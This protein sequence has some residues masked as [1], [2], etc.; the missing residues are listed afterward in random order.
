M[1]TIS[2]L[3]SFRH[4]NFR[5]FFSGQFVSMTG[6]WMQNTAQM[7]L[8]YRLT[9]SPVLLGLVGFFGQ[10]P[11]LFLGL[12]GGW[13]ADRFDRRRVIV[14]TQVLAMIQAFLLAALTYSGHVRVEQVMVLALFLGTVTAFD[15]PAR[16]S[17][18]VRMVGP[19]DLPNAI[20]L[21]STLVN[22]SRM[23]GPAAAG[24]LVGL[25]GEGV[26][27]LVNGV[28]YLAV[29]AGLLLMRLP[30]E[31]ARLAS[32]NFRRTLREG[33]GYAA[34]HP[35]IRRLL[36]LLAV[37]SLAGMPFMVLLPMFADGIFA[38]GPQGLGWLTCAMGLGAVMGAVLLAGRRNG[39]GIGGTAGRGAVLFGAGLMLFAVSR[40]Y[41]LSLA[42]AAVAGAGM[43][44]SFASANTR[45]QSLTT[46]AMRGRVMSLF[47]MTFMGVAPLGSLLAGLLAKRAGAPFA[48]FTGGVA[49][50][51]GGVFFL[52]GNNR[53]IPTPAVLGNA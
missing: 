6:T 43:M 2:L 19:E 41:G 11:V 48:V 29:I 50:A 13:A 51:A 53:G 37:V 8:V 28:S 10:A 17:F 40:S 49:C 27:F 30:P 39:E 42:L 31:Q 3:R 38:R 35:E 4:R 36:F 32:G 20:A 12:V 33:V 5:L 26:C 24:I 15:M 34:R 14:L 1:R 16:Q 47:G 25:S 45:M 9:K 18:V 22:A 7:W 52:S 46:E 23:V 21:N 44:T